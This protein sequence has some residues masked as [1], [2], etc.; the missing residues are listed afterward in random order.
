MFKN[1]PLKLILAITG[2]VA[3]VGAG[4]LILYDRT[5]LFDRFPLIGEDEIEIVI[6]DGSICKNNVTDQTSEMLI[7]K[8]DYDGVEEFVEV[9]TSPDGKHICFLAQDMVPRWVYYAEADGTDVREEIA[10]A[11]NCVW[12]NN[13]DK[14]AFINHTTDVSPHNVY[15]YDIE[16]KETT[17]LTES[18][19]SYE[20]E[21]IYQTPVWS[22]DDSTIRSKYIQYDSTADWA[23]TQGESEIN[24]ATGEV[25]DL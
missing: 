18:V 5:D 25:T 3:I 7:Y 13:S 17:N 10:L 15:V 4:V 8:G 9:N 1:L 24:L 14:F 22:D 12:S 23:E 19:N 20:I 21:R 11:I 6:C 16:T 2:G